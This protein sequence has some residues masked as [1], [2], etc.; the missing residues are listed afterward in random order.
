[1]IIRPID[2]ASDAD[3]VAAIYNHYILHTTVTFE[4]EPLSVAAMRERILRYT[5]D[6]PWLVAEEEGRLVGY[7]YATGFRV[8]QAYAHTCEVSVYCAP[9]AVGR[10]WGRALLQA[11]LDQ[12]RQDPR[13]FMVIAIITGNNLPS[14]ALFTR[15]GFRQAGRLEKVGRKFGQ[16]IDTYDYQYTLREGEPE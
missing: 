10:G 8:R 4:T 11:V 15:L 5:A 6:Y 14:L 16:W 3:A 1:M 13:R 7:A 2:P 9:D 12:L